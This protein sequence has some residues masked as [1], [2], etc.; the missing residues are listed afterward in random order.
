MM[1][2]LGLVAKVETV[3]KQTYKVAALMARRAETPEQETE[4][5]WRMQEFSG[6]VIDA[7]QQLTKVYPK[8]GTPEPYS[9]AAFGV[10]LG[11]RQRLRQPARPTGHLSSVIRLNR[12]TSNK[13]SVSSPQ[14]E[15]RMLAVVENL[16]VFLAT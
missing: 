1:I 15:N 16:G 12:D 9:L 6:V 11:L 13:I 5:W 2:S 4:V 3:L 14:S 7:P 8:C 10:L